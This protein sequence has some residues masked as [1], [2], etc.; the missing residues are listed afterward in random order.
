MKASFLLFVYKRQ[1][2]TSCLRIISSK[3]TVAHTLPLF[4]SP[5]I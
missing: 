4:P 2:Y 5:S 1:P 3:G